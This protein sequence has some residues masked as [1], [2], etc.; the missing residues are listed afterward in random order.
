MRVL[1]KLSTVFAYIFT[2]RYTHYMDYPHYNLVLCV[3]VCVR[4]RVCVCMCVC[5][6][7]RVCVWV[8]VCVHVFV[9]VWNLLPH[10]TV[11]P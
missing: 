11:H 6:C 5:V 4:V 1:L 7:V 10:S 9:G 2:G 3:C 8:W